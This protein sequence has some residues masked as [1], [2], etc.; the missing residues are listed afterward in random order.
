M[1]VVKGGKG[2]EV[3]NHE[4]LLDMPDVAGTNS[5]HDTRYYTE[6]EVSVTGVPMVVTDFISGVSVISGTSIDVDSNLIIS[7]TTTCEGNLLVSGANMMILSGVEASVWDDHRFPSLSLTKGGVRAPDLIKFKDDGESTGVFTYH[8]DKTTEE[9]L[10]FIAQMPHRWKLETDL[11]PHVHWTPIDADTGTVKWGLEYTWQSISGVYGN[12]DIISGIQT[13]NGTAY[14][15]HYLNLPDISATGKGLSSIL[16][17]R[18]FRES[19]NDTYDADA[20]LL[21]ID[22]H[23]EIDTMGSAGETMKWVEGEW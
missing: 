22:F 17:C 10:F 5:D 2:A 11:H 18:V 7:G 23:Y 3:L 4:D 1:V 9:E 12:T 19:A 14:T 8:F 15:H 16:V 20:A 21:E 6:T 13:A